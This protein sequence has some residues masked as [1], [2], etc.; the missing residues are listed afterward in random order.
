MVCLTVGAIGQGIIIIPTESNPTQTIEP[1]VDKKDLTSS[2]PYLKMAR[3]LETGEQT[4]IFKTEVQSRTLNPVWREIQVTCVVLLFCLVVKR[5]ENACLV[6]KAS[7]RLGIRVLFR[8]RNRG[9]PRAFGVERARS[10]KR[11]FRSAPF[12]FTFTFTPRV[13]LARGRDR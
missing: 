3:V 11:L 10:L 4:Y 5:N 2:D 7:R 12:T 6:R 1:Q 13:A 9:Y 8:V